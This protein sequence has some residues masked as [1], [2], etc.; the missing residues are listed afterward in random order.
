MGAPVSAV[1]IALEAL[2]LISIWIMLYQLMKQQGRILLRLDELAEHT[3][4]NKDTGPAAGLAVGTAFPS[5]S[6]PDL[7]GQTIALE[8]FLG[9]RV[10][11]VNWSPQCG[12]CELIAPDLSKFQPDFLKENVQL[13]LLSHGTAESD[14]KLAQEHGLVCPILL[15][16][17]T[18]PPEPFQSIGTPAAYLLDEQGK[19]AKAVAVGAD[20]VPALA[21]ES[22]GQGSSS[23]SKKKRLRGERALN[24]SRIERNGLKPGTPAPSFQLP[25]IHGSTVSLEEYRGRRVLLV[26]SDPHCGPCDE[27]APQLARLHQEHRD[28]NLAI[29]MV[30]RGDAEENRSKA[31]RHGVEFPVVL[32]EQWKLSKEYGIFVT[33]VAFLIGEDG[34]I[35][36]TVARGVEEILALAPQAVVKEIL[37]KGA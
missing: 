16:Q 31:E 8:N 27:L 10:L 9:K 4:E 11:L 5:F 19:V 24:E 33:P 20:R 17:G 28:N 36:K 32:Q 35:K 30:G 26:F 23:V 1:L 13:L 3:G 22:V 14:G 37:R 12:F 2:T 6:F 25:D 15:M 21:R 29:I 7:A 34:L 18:Q